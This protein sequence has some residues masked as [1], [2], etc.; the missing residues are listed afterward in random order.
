M[1]SKRIILVVLL[2]LFSLKTYELN[3][4][5]ELLTVENIISCEAK[6]LIPNH[7]PTFHLEYMYMIGMQNNIPPKILFRLIYKESTFRINA[8]SKRGA[9]GYMQIMPNTINHYSKKF[10]IPKY[11]WKSKYY[12]WYF[13]IK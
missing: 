2:S 4:C 1:A 11:T 6:I 5:N 8:K 12:N 9:I 13:I 7:V 10:N 3:K